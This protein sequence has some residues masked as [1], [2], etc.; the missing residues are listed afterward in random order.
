MQPCAISD[1]VTDIYPSQVL[2]KDLA[3]KGDQQYL[4]TSH[5]TAADFMMG[6]P[7]VMMQDLQD[8][9][10]DVS[11]T[12]YPNVVKYIQRLRSLDSGKAVFGSYNSLPAGLHHISSKAT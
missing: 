1:G 8:I 2:D 6:Y 3:H 9:Y 7:L 12:S 10:K 5:P 4:I 11:L